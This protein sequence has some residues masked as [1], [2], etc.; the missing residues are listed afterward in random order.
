MCDPFSA[1]RSLIDWTLAKKQFEDEIWGKLT[2][3]FGHT[4]PWERFWPSFPTSYRLDQTRS[5]S[6]F[7]TADT[8]RPAHRVSDCCSVEG[9]QLPGANVLGDPLTWMP[10]HPQRSEGRRFLGSS[11]GGRMGLFEPELPCDQA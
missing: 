2:G 9:D 5:S 8:I 10:S 3:R 4:N 6:A 1:L 11:L 7:A